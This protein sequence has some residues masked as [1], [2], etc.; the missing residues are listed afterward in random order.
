MAK[1]GQHR[2]ERQRKFAAAYV[3][4][5]NAAEA[6]REAGYSESYA[7]HRTDALVEKCRELIEQE[8]AKME[9]LEIIKREEVLRLWRDLMNGKSHDG[10]PVPVAVRL[11]ASE[12][13]AKALGMFTE[14][15]EVG[16][17]GQFVVALPEPEE[18]G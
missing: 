7:A 14:K 5:G 12:A 9:K 13:A 17:Q 4:L 8:R 6:A 10:E 18:D 1:N 16:V 3:R 2:S 15:R 11:R